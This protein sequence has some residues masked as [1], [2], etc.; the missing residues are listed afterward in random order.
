MTQGFCEPIVRTDDARH[1][2]ACDQAFAILA[3]RG[4]GGIAAA[5]AAVAQDDAPLDSQAHQAL[6]VQVL[7]VAAEAFATEPQT[8]SDALTQCPAALAAGIRGLLHAAL[9][10]NGEYDPLAFSDGL[11]LCDIALQA[12]I[13]ERVA[14]LA[15]LTS[16]AERRY[17]GFCE[18]AAILRTT[19]APFADFKPKLLIWDLDDTLWQGTLAEG[20]DVRP[21]TRRV[22]IL[23]VLNRHGIVSAI[24]SK[25]DPAIA[26]SKLQALGLWDDFVFPRIAFAPKGEAVKRLVADMQLRAENVLFLDDNPH[27]LHEV[28]AC[29]PGIRTID[30]TT[31][32]CDALLED[33]LEQHR[34]VTRDR[35]DEYRVL[36]ARV[37]ER[38]GTGLSHEAF[39]R[40]SEI[41]VLITQLTENVHFAERIEEL[42]NRSNQLNYTHSRVTP[43]TM[44]DHI[45]DFTRN[46]TDAVF[47]RDKYG[48]YGLAGFV[49]YD[50]TRSIVT[51][52]VLSCRVMHM[53]IEAAMLHRL[54][55][56]FGS[57]CFPSSAK[58][59]PWQSA[60]HIAFETSADPANL[61]RIRKWADAA[62]PAKP[63][64][65]IMFDC[66]SG[67]LQHYSKYRDEIDI[68][69]FPRVFSLPM[70]ETGEYAG[71]NFPKHLV[72]S[73]NSDYHP[74]RWEI[75][76]LRIGRDLYERCARQFCDV[77][78]QGDHRLLVV[79][80]PEDCP[81]NYYYAHK[82]VDGVTYADN[83]LYFNSLWRDLAAERPET[84]QVLDLTGKFPHSDMTC[85]GH[86]FP[87]RLQE[88]S[89][90]IDDWYGGG[91]GAD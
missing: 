78:V 9:L 49:S 22:E 38:E 3:E 11:Q 82:A 63:N 70:M 84:V 40:S 4:G 83:Y 17:E 69:G 80:P 14:A 90:W 39:L 5:F 13:G 62:P 64:I 87:Q 59:R 48:D 6:Y 43:G 56:A 55:L 72:L 34:H 61:A 88:L 60:E 30:A 15:L 2:T 66:Q 85:A 57:V 31:P 42:I 28:A 10:P 75:R 25:N 45:L 65:R 7:A 8:V 37:E 44:K 52:F 77:L 16:E 86:Y 47:V 58:E 36:Q 89:G 71:Q 24:C 12:A 20:D 67:A 32:E 19:I 27:N 50:C 53:G 51:H 54:G 41:R 74:W 68:D 79:L 33:M 26:R 1:E 46:F 18:A 23:Q 73:A 91:S 76:K 81:P 21:F 29:V 35:R